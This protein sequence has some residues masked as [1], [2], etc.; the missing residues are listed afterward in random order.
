[1]LLAVLGLL[2]TQS[3]LQ[4]NALKQALS[5]VIG[6]LATSLPERA[7]TVDDGGN[8]GAAKNL[9]TGHD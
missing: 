1:M 6:G 9:R 2:T 7:E 5:F 4:V 8:G 3:L